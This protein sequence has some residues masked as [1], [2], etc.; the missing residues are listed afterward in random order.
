MLLYT[1]WLPVVP[2]GRL[3]HA[4]CSAAGIRLTEDLTCSVTSLAM[5]CHDCAGNCAS[6][7]MDALLNSDALTMMVLESLPLWY[8]P[9]LVGPA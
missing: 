5:I 7:R 1:A 3:V 4:T 6:L 9:L 2:Q 8:F